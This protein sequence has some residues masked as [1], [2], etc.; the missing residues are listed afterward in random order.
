Q[1]LKSGV[2]RIY[3]DSNNR[4]WMFTPRLSAFSIINSVF[5]SSGSQ[6]ADFMI[7]IN[8][9]TITASACVGHSVIFNVFD[10]VTLKPFYNQAV[11]STIP[12][13]NYGGFLG[14]GSPCN[15]GGP[16]ATEHNFEFSYLDTT[17]RR[18]MRDFMDWVPAGYIVTARLILDG[19]Q[20][21]YAQEPFVGVWKND[22]QYYGAGNT[23]YQRLKDAGFTAFDD[24]TYARTW[25]FIYQKNTSSFSPQW[26]MSIGLSDQVSLKLDIATPDT[27]GYITSPA[28]GPA[29][30]WKQVK[31]RGSSLDTKPGD[32]ATVDVIGVSVTGTET[33]L[34][35]LSSLQQDFDISSVSVL[36]YPFLKLR[37][38]NADSVNLTPYQLRYWRILYDPVPEGAL[39]PN[40]LYSFK[41][42]LNLGEQSLFTMAFKNISDVSFTDSIKV[43]FTVT[44][45]SN[46]TSSLF[47]PRL[48][49]LNPGDTAT[50]TYLVDSKNFT[51]KN[52]LFLDVNPDNNQ[53][54]QHHFNNF[55][56][57]D[58][59]VA[60][61]DY[62][63]ILDVTFD[64]LHIL[65]NDIVSAQPHIL[66]KLKDESKY[67]LLNDTALL[68]VQLQYPDGTLRRFYFN[69]DTL[70]F[71]PATP[72]GADNTA[73]VD[74]TPYFLEDGTYQ[75]IVHG[76]D[77]KGNNAGS[78]D[79]VVSFQVYNKP[80]ISNMFNY[81]NPFTTSTAFVFTITGSQVPQNI[82]IQVLTITGKIVK[83]ITKDELGLLRI[84][85][86]ITEYKWDGTDMYG[87]KL[88][89][90]VYLYRVITNLNGNR[91]DKFPTY[92]SDGYEL[93]TDKYFNKGYGKMYLMR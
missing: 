5:P 65:N 86:N 19:Y 25:A 3:I 64:G 45:A 26:K 30:A 14:S 57:K 37:M 2:E 23:A 36:S 10:P 77:Q 93:N 8:G 69:N 18:K 24:Y 52:N 74:F 41:D 31:W 80:M 13:G 12:S 62:N 63:P 87:Q 44:D 7:Q 27:L 53:P 78:T 4:K 71:T 35:T 89:N 21:N 46:V 83:E 81:P 70:R 39:A 60:S 54:E 38:R 66:I 59:V 33:V 16:I 47:L 75:L 73:T 72:G 15:V 68:N 1:H 11:P 82:R 67:L 49:K 40:I 61:D 28:F 90:G 56:Y 20:N 22:D 51:G 29:A 84:G 79:Y 91:L 34:Y 58:F 76:Q 17:G 32:L 55:L 50:I 43:N 92:G 42:T 48:K 6:P 9:A 88:A 85:R